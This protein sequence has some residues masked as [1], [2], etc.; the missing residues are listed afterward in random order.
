MTGGVIGILKQ[1]SIPLLF[2]SFLAL[3]LIVRAG[4]PPP[5]PLVVPTLVPY[6]TLQ[7]IT[8]YVEGLSEIPP[9]KY[10]FVE[11]WY[12][13]GGVG[14]CSDKQKW[15]DY[16]NYRYSG[17]VGNDGTLGA[18]WVR[19][20]RDSAPLDQAALNSVQGFY[21][22][23]DGVGLGMGGGAFSELS[24]ITAFPYLAHYPEIFGVYARGAIVAKLEDN[25]YLIEPGQ[26]WASRSADEA[27]PETECLTFHTFKFTNHGLLDKSQLEVTGANE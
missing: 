18:S 19:F 3:V 4:V 12:E 13:Y 2:V 9:G 24:A 20:D 10:L 15:A 6:P 21:G 26:V 25:T 23:G 16:P 27:T 5:A 22:V 17:G 11:S 7:P 8:D 14:Q 1:Y